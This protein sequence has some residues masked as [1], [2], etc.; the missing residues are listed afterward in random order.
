MKSLIL[1][2][3]VFLIVFVT[4]SIAGSETQINCLKNALEESQIDKNEYDRQD[5]N[6]KHFTIDVAEELKSSGFDAGRTILDTCDN[7]T[8][9]HEVVWVKIDGRYVFVDPQTD[10]FINSFEPKYKKFWILNSSNGEVIEVLP[11]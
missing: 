9:N 5:Y 11:C 4:G 10:L 7:Q 3:F 1:L 2:L 6:C 8:D